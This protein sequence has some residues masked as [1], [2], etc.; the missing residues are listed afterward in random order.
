MITKTTVS[1]MKS[2]QPSV[3]AYAYKKKGTFQNT[4]ALCNLGSF[5]VILSTHI[6]T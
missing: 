6:Q 3:G 1:G 4:V 2:I 5:K